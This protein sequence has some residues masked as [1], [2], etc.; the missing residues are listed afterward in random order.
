MRLWITVA[1]SKRRTATNRPLSTKGYGTRLSGEPEVSTCKM[2]YLKSTVCLIIMR[3]RMDLDRW[4][5]S[6]FTI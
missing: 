2:L 5:K 3:L 6:S 1:V 4:R